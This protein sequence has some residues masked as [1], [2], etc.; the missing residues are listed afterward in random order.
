MLILELVWLW[1]TEQE[2]IRKILCTYPVHIKLQ[3]QKARQLRTINEHIRIKGNK[4][5]R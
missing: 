3:Q 4:N 2:N 1:G 5:N